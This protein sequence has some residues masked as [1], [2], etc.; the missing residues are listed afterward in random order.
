[1]RYYLHLFS[2]ETA[3]A[4]TD[5]SQ[6]V[7]GFRI[8]RRTYVEN[9]KIGPGDKF[10]CYVTRIQRFVGVLEVQSNYYIDKKPIFTSE[11]DPF[12]LRFKVKPL[13]WL[14]LEKSI[15]IYFEEYGITFSS[16]KDL[17]KTILSGP[18]WFV[19]RLGFGHRK[20]VSLL[21]IY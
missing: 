8:S 14:P 18:I 15:P 10:I 20:M 1:M 13:V 9:Q 21:K 2:P 11:N 5:S 4:F 6:E 7:S 16:Q 19:V 17:Q 3:K 12:I